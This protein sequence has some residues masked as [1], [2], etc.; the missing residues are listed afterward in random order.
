[1]ISSWNK[2]IVDE[3]NLLKS[4]L[5]QLSWDQWQVR[6]SQEGLEYK[7][8]AWNM[9]IVWVIEVRLVAKR[10]RERGRWEG[11]VG[12]IPAIPAKQEQWQFT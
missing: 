5:Q 10:E 12:D 6:L 2:K 9:K 3:A 7:L 1:M 8:Q 4:H 11:G